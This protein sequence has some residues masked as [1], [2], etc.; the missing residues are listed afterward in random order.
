MTRTAGQYIRM[1]PLRLDRR[2]QYAS[3]T[4]C[5]VLGEAQDV[6]GHRVG[7]RATVGTLVHGGLY[8]EVPGRQSTN[9]V[10][11]SASNGERSATSFTGTMCRSAAAA[12][13]PPGQRHLSRV[14]NPS[15]AMA[16]A[17]RTAA[18]GGGLITRDCSNHNAPDSTMNS[19]SGTSRQSLQD[20]H[21]LAEFPVRLG[22]P[23]TQIA[24]R[25]GVG[26]ASR[27]IL[28]SPHAATRCRRRHP[29]RIAAEHDTGSGQIRAASCMSASLPMA[30]AS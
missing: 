5:D 15:R 25:P 20:A 28:P 9:W 12:S 7:Y 17:C 26:P 24:Q 3:L 14:I 1:A 27:E 6:T 22:H 8:I 4:W 19:T 21:P 30:Q 16:S 13:V 11:S 18:S 29:H 23:G 2:D 10:I